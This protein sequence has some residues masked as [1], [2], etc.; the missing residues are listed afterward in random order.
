MRRVAND[1]VSA[2]WDL[3]RLEEPPVFRAEHYDLQHFCMD[4]FNGTRSM[5][6][7]AWCGP[8]MKWG[9]VFVAT[10]FGVL[11]ADPA[12]YRIYVRALGGPKVVWR[13][14]NDVVRKCGKGLVVLARKAQ[15]GLA[16]LEAQDP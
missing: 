2:L 10:E 14:A 12:L 1:D 3:D 9:C 5:I 8:S 16:A 4:A 11:S 7:T 13:A 6:D 15:E